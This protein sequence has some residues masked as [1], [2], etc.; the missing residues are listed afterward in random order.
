MDKVMYDLSTL[1]GAN[2]YGYGI[3]D[4]GHTVGES[5]LDAQHGGHLHAFWWPLSHI[6]DI[7][8]LGGPTSVGYAI[9]IT[10][11]IIGQ[12]DTASG[13]NHAFLWTPT[14]P[15]N[16]STGQM[17]DLGTLGGSK[18]SAQGLN[19]SGQVVGIASL[20][21]GQQHAFLWDPNTPNGSTGQMADLGTLGGQNS[22]AEDINTTGQV[23]GAALDAHQVAHAFLWPSINGLL[24]DLNGYLPANSGWVLAY[25][26]AIN[27]SGQIVGAGTMNGHYHA[28]LLTPHQA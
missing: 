26:R 23:V 3:N 14:N 27:D 2:S 7:G 19:T 28:F 22:L 13:P 5:N 1:N 21:S 25:A 12:A 8:T 6:I 20:A 11:Q 10:C 4:N 15:C 17:A 18:S 9:N 16:G 24:I